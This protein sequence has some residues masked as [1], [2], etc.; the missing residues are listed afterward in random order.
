MQD[1]ITSLRK[2]LHDLWIP[3]MKHLQ[4]ASFVT[5]TPTL[6]H[7]GTPKEKEKEDEDRPSDD[8]NIEPQ[9]MR[10]IDVQ[11]EVGE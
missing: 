2:H 7:E 4:R 9:I 10:Q 1:E 6:L 5:L 8:K 3:Y 11:N